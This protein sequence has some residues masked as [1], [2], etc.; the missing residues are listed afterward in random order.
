MAE[1]G[2][3]G[4]LRKLSRYVGGDAGL[5][6]AV[7]LDRQ[8]E[9]GRILGQA[10]GL[11]VELGEGEVIPNSE[12]DALG[13][14]LSQVLELLEPRETR[15]AV[16]YDGDDMMGVRKDLPNSRDGL[17]EVDRGGIEGLVPLARGQGRG[18]GEMEDIA[19]GLGEE[20]GDGQYDLG[21]FRALRHDGRYT[22]FFIF[23]RE[24]G[25]PGLGRGRS[26]E[27]T[28]VIGLLVDRRSLPW[29]DF[30]YPFIE[31]RADHGPP[32]KAVG[33]GIDDEDIPFPPS[34]VGRGL[35]KEGRLKAR[36]DGQ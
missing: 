27:P 32:G 1:D 11:G 14:G 12:I 13:H 35:G 33:V 20:P 21:G 7:D 31:A 17:S 22:H 2:N 23:F 28:P 6:R 5:A 15:G 24:E 4:G 36:S 18:G 26:S 8:V 25:L 30:G 29:G 9:E 10:R 16:I 34:L 19:L 3:L